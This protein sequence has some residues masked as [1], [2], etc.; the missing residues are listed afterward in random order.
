MADII[1]QTHILFEEAFG[2][3]MREWPE[4][5]QEL[6]RNCTRHVGETHRRALERGR[7]EGYSLAVERIQAYMDL[8]VDYGE[9]D[10]E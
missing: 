8:T 6:V 9:E 5:A 3:N 2:T 4:G 1:R 10:S 7:V